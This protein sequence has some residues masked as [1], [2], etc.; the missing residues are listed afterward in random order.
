MARAGRAG[1]HLPLARHFRPPWTDQGN[2]R[3]TRKASDSKRTAVG[4]RA[5]AIWLRVVQDEQARCGVFYREPSQCLLC[6]RCRL[7]SNLL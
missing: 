4:A 3:I 7:D 6:W 5:P 1:A 2:G